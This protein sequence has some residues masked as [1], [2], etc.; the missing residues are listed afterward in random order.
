MSRRRK[1]TNFSDSLGKNMAGK[2]LYFDRLVELSVSMFEWKNLPETVD[3]RLLELCLFYNGSAV[4]FRDEVLGDLALRCTV[5]G[6]YDVNDVPIYRRAFANNGYQRELDNTNSVLIYNNMLRTNSVG[7]IEYFSNR[8]YELDSIIDVNAKAQKTPVL[9]QCVENQRLTMENLY[10]E[11]DGN[12]PV[13]YGDKGLDPKGLSVLKTDAPYIAD[14]LYQLK[15]QI[16]NE[17]LTYLGISNVNTTKKER[18][19]TDEVIRNMGGTIASR[20]SRL[21]MR[22]KAAKQINDMFGLDLDVFYRADYREADD[23]VM[24]DGHTGEY[25]AKDMVV[26]LRT[27]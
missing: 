17:A 9:I 21:E 26:D 19:V 3:E 18:M 20:Y 11:Y 22:R 15:S 27:E 12:S 6:G 25:A 8:L 5:Q 13:I 16:W 24:L 23:E 7:A 14:K 10:K 1:R 4:F 2:N